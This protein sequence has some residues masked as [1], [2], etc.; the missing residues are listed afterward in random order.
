MVSTGRTARAEQE[1]TAA[2]ADKQ[3]IVVRA[4][5]PEIRVRAEKAL[6][7]QTAITD[8]E[9]MTIMDREDQAATAAQAPA[10][11]EGALPDRRQPEERRGSLFLQWRS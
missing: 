7:E 8:R 6:T 1:D 2:R 3:A 10:A 9:A 4:A 5:G 11:K